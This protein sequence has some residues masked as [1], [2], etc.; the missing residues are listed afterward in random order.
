MKK[1]KHQDIP[2][3][4]FNAKEEDTKAYHALLRSGISCKFHAAAEE[5]TP[6]LLVG[7][8]RFSGLAKIQEFISEW[9]QRSSS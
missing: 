4:F 5:P 2:M 6:L 9:N 1:Q 8:Q 7:Y 3:L